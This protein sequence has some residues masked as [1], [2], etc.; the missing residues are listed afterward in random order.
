MLKFYES[1]P[2]HLYHR[3]EIELFSEFHIGEQSVQARLLRFNGL[4]KDLA[5]RPITLLFVGRDSDGAFRYSTESH[6]SP[7]LI[8][9]G[10]AYRSLNLEAE[11]A[12]VAV[13]MGGP[14]PDV[15]IDRIWLELTL[16]APGQPNFK[17]Q[18]ILH[19]EQ[20]ADTSRLDEMITFF[21]S[22]QGVSEGMLGAL[23]YRLR[24]LSARVAEQR[25]PILP[26][27]L[28]ERERATMSTLLE[29]Q[30]D[31]CLSLSAMLQAQIENAARALES[32]FSVSTA[33]PAPRLLSVSVNPATGRLRTDI[34]SLNE[35]PL[36]NNPADS[37]AAPAIR[38]ALGVTSSAQEEF[39]LR[40]LARLAGRY[41]RGGGPSSLDAVATTEQYLRKG[42]RWLA[43]DKNNVGELDRMDFSPEFRAYLEA[44]TDNGFVL[45]LPER[46]SSTSRIPLAWWELNPATGSVLGMIYPGLGGAQAELPEDWASIAAAYPPGF[47]RGWPE[48]LA[49]LC[50]SAASLVSQ[51]T[52]RWRIEICSYITDSLLDIHTLISTALARSPEVKLAPQVSN[53]FGSEGASR[54]KSVIGIICP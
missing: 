25:L 27:A 47:N 8:A 34:L 7:V 26:Q 10:R 32:G 23:A 18:R 52:S 33:A 1:T 43:V 49:A 19:G 5:G 40:S 3:L 16:K 20:E 24:T 28:S 29:A 37:L 38:F 36:P 42:V 17:A 9:G 2:T 35:F 6:H 50:R 31:L 22:T 30:R 13:R 4:L 39:L 14:K 11:A 21:V 45:I 44:V 46:T 53:F 12:R 51:G 41:A 15:S 54:L 48:K